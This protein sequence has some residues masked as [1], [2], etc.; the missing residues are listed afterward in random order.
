M[1]HTEKSVKH[2]DSSKTSQR[3]E[4]YVLRP[5][6]H[7]GGWKLQ[8]QNSSGQTILQITRRSTTPPR[9]NA[10]IFPP[11]EIEPFVIKSMTI[12]DVQR[13]SLIEN[14]HEALSIRRVTSSQVV[15]LR[16]A[17]RQVVARFT[18]ISS[19]IILLRTDTTSVGRLRFKETPGVFGFIA[20]CSTVAELRWL[21]AVIL[22]VI[23]RLEE[24]TAVTLAEAP[25]VEEVNTE[26]EAE[27]P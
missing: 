24:K 21:H 25:V 4:Q 1:S 12:G 2:P 20:D 5:K 11:Y 13:Y 22:Y 3:T 6:L 27:T 15:L 18:P 8:V 19:E 7:P 9:Y 17:Q 14:G 10:R 26:P 16:D 23:A